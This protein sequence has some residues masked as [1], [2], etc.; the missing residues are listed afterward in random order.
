MKASHIDVNGIHIRWLE[1]GAGQPLVLLHGIPTS[2]GLWRHVVPLI[3]GARCLAW[4]M[5]G[6]GASIREGHR[7]D[8]SVARQADYLASWMQAIGIDKAVLVGHDLGGGVAQ[9]FAVRHPERVRGLV[10]MNAIAY[11]S[12]PVLPVKIIRGLG[13]G[14]ERLP[15]R[16]F[17]PALRFFVQQGHDNRARAEESFHEHWQHYA[18]ADSAAAAF[19]HQV[20]SLDVRDTLMVADSIAGLNVPARL[21]WG[22]ADQFQTI[23][24]GYRLAHDLNARLERI[25]GARHFVPED[26]P[27]RVAKAVNDLLA[28]VAP[29]AGPLDP[30]IA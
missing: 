3:E 30:N 14:V 15:D 7:R 11:D 27:E 24:Y 28:E 18:A 16:L 21:V 19:V 4:E 25:E 1:A 12:W 23:G 29:V 22:V 13:M 9:I 8:I 17:E 10:L 6:Y 26:H 5:V 2:P 20:R